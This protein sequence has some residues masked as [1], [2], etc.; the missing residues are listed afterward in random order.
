[1]PEATHFALTVAFVLAFV[2]SDLKLCAWVDYE[3]W[4][5]LS[6]CIVNWR[7]LQSAWEEGTQ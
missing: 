7:R 1:V 6:S 5:E 2:S 3:T 4:F